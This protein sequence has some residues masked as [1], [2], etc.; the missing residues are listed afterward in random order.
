MDL[1]L[2]IRPLESRR[3]PSAFP[4][5]DETAAGRIANRALQGRKPST[6]NIAVAVQSHLPLIAHHVSMTQ[7]R[8]AHRYEFNVRIAML[9]QGEDGSGRIRA[10]TNHL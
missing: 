4:A 8:A 3:D 5:D 7:V 10:G 2:T 9:Q 6:L 1:G